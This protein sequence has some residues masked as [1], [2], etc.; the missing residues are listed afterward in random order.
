VAL[1]VQQAHPLTMVTAA[2]PVIISADAGRLRQVIDNLLN[3]ALQH[4]PAGTKVT[5][6]VE[7]ISGDAQ[8]TVTDEGPGM[9][10]EQALHVFER[11]Y[12]TDYARSRSSGGTGLGL[13]IAAA[14]VA[15]HQGTISVDTGPGQGTAFRVRLPLAVAGEAAAEDL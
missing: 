5:V 14:L 1:A 9:T 15:A 3:N 7:I 13:S 2:D 11:F 6:A 8:L 4:T 12:R 10:T